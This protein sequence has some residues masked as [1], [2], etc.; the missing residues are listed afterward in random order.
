MK[1]LLATVAVI[2]AFSSAA[3]ADTYTVNAEVTNVEANMIS[4][5]RAVP[6]ERCELVRV[7]VTETRRSGGSGASSGDVLGG[8]ILGGLIGKGASGDDQGAAI[9]A[10]LGGMIA[11]DNNRGSSYE[12][13]TGYRN[14]QQCYTVNEYTT[15]NTRDGS[16]VTYSWNGL[17]GQ[18]HTYGTYNVGE[19]IRVNVTI[20]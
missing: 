9:G 12:V 3:V 1:T 15:I 2:A 16:I 5:D 7:P 18:L 6:V 10:I 19:E 4:V 13:V 11:A 17:V 8:M 14:E 20:N